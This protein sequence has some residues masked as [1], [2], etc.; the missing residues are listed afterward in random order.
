MGNSAL[1]FNLLAT[2]VNHCHRIG[3][4]KLPLAKNAKELN[5]LVQLLQILWRHFVQYLALDRS[6]REFAQL[7]IGQLDQ[8][9]FD[10]DEILIKQLHLGISRRQQL[11]N[12]LPCPIAA[13]HFET[14]NGGARRGMIGKGRNGWHILAVCV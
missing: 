5:V 8:L 12:A 6:R 2:V 14:I 9:K 10:R 13:G 11:A 4:F 7:L 3:R 1:T